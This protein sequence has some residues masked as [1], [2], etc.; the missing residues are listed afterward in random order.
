MDVEKTKEPITQSTK[1]RRERSSRFKVMFYVIGSENS[2]SGSAFYNSRQQNQRRSGA[3]RHFRCTDTVS[4]E[5]TY[6]GTLVFSCLCSGS[7]LCHHYTDTSLIRQD[8]ECLSLYS[9][10]QR[11]VFNGIEKRSLYW[12]GHLG[13]NYQRFGKHFFKTVLTY[14][15][16][17]HSN[18]YPMQKISLYL[19][20]HFQEKYQRAKNN[21]VQPGQKL[22]V[23]LSTRK[24][25]PT[26]YG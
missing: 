22:S 3:V 25:R 15:Q 7:P 26:F 16:K 20:G 9:E 1:N 17:K 10:F 23:Y 6:G 19:L 2:K 5:P 18:S 8:S 11:P 21:S 4:D 12:L 24:K 13:A 14:L